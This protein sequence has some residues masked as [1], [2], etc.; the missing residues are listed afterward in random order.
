MLTLDQFNALYKEYKREKFKDIKL[1]HV[2]PFTLYKVKK[3][4]IK[5]ELK[6][7]INGIPYYDKIVIVIENPKKIFQVN[8]F[9]ALIVAYLKIFTNPLRAEITNTKGNYIP[10]VGYIPNKEKG[11]ADI[12]SQYETFEL[13]IETKQEYEKQL[14]SQ[15]SFEKM[16]QQQSFRK[17]VLVRDFEEFQIEM[18]KIFKNLP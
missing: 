8:Q 14:D 10:N 9:N 4:K 6:Q 1:H 7:D 16:S 11:R 2:K 3:H 5:K 13:C 18:K 12:T 17:Y 15:K